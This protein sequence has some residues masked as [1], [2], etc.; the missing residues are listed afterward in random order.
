M[1]NYPPATWCILFGTQCAVLR[2]M[3]VMQVLTFKRTCWTWWASSHWCHRWKTWI[4][5]VSANEEHLSE[6]LFRFSPFV[7][8]SFANKYVHA[9]VY[10]SIRVCMGTLW[11][12]VATECCFSLLISMNCVYRQT[13]TYTCC[14][15]L[16]MN[17][18]V[19]LLVENSTTN[20]VLMGQPRYLWSS[21]LYTV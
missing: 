17:G 18:L 9:A 13:H 5:D 15:H 19:W 14:G 21:D 10:K 6:E 1:C 4:V 16:H 7:W 2:W 20:S 11:M 12:Y 8:Y 3:C